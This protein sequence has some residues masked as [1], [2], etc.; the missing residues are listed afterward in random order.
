MIPIDR[1]CG[2]AETTLMPSI[3]IPPQSTS[4]NPAM[5]C[6]KVDFPQPEG[7]INATSSPSSTCNETL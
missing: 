7:P 1:S 3:E 6:N 5:Q 4:S 2:F